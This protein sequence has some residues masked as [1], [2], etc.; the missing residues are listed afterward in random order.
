MRIGIP[1]VAVLLAGVVVGCSAKDMQEWKAHPSHFASGDHMTFSLKNQGSTP[2]VSS[3]DT[4]LAASQ[5]WW[6]EPVVVRADQ[7]FQN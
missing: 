5:A 1:V 2:R 7:I 3:T 4:K 6:G